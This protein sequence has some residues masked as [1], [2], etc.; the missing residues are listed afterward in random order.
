MLGGVVIVYI[1][2][3]FKRGKCSIYS[4]TQY[5]TY[6]LHISDKVHKKNLC[7]VRSCAFGLYHE[8]IVS[9]TSRKHIGT[10]NGGH[11]SFGL[12]M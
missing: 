9:D 5:I 1:K 8:R 10:K 11:M 3:R 7:I 4:S 12:T 2:D 6:I